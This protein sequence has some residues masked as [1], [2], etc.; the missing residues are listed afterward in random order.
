MLY[1]VLCKWGLIRQLHL[2]KIIIIMLHSSNPLSTHWVRYWVWVCHLNPKS[3]WKLTWD[4][5]LEQNRLPLSLYQTKALSKLVG[6]GVKEASP[7]W[8]WLDALKESMILKTVF[9]VLGKCVILS[10]ISLCFSALLWGLD[11]PTLPEA[12][13]TVIK[14]LNSC[15]YPKTGTT[16]NT[17]SYPYI[18][19]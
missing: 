8:Q 7:A 5:S 2:I 11:P 4:A 15:T 16:R 14:S 9:P 1:Q 17:L 13:I 12:V 18:E 19:P 3:Q 6:R 10:R